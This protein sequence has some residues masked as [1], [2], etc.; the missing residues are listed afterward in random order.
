MMSKGCTAWR[1]I[2]LPLYLPRYTTGVSKL[3]TP[4]VYEQVFLLALRPAGCIKTA[5]AATHQRVLSTL[6]AYSTYLYE[7]LSFPRNERF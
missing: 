2:I 7:R 3:I 5:V 1:R 6:L 4:T